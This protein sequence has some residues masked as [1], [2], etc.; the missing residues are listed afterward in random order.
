MLH[1]ESQ[2]KNGHKNDLK[3][4]EIHN[5]S[6]TLIIKNYLQLNLKKV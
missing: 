6:K 2:L 3:N 5:S 1:N 4:Y